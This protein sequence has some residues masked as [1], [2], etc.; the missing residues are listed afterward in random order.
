MCCYL[1]LLQDVPIEKHCALKRAPCGLK[2][3]GSFV[4]DVKNSTKNQNYSSLCFFF[5]FTCFYLAFCESF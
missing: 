5:F 4:C 3:R 1:M 2:G